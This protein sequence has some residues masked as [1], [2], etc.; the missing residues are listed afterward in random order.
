MSTRTGRAR[1]ARKYL[2]DLG[3]TFGG[4]HSA[5]HHSGLDPAPS[6]CRREKVSPHRVIR[7]D[8]E[9]LALN[10]EHLLT[11]ASQ[12]GLRVVPVTSVQVWVN[13]AAE[14]V[15]AD[16]RVFLGEEILSRFGLQVEV[17]HK[18]LIASSKVD[19]FTA[20]FNARLRE[21]WAQRG[22]P[23]DI[24]DDYFDRCSEAGMTP[25]QCAA[26]WADDIPLELIP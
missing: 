23:A 25:E 9:N 4:R 10:V 20:D 3:V 17:R 5:C 1:E 16:E 19:A 22:V 6:W 26:Y 8:I 13:A 18:A 21:A 11:I 7:L 15:E 24:P 2:D 12:S 14:T